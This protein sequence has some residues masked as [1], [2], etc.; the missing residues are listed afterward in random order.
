MQLPHLALTVIEDPDHGGAYH[1]LLL[2]SADDG[3]PVEHSASELS[4]PS[5]VQAFQAGV[6]RW[7]ELTTREDEDADPVGDNVEP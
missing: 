3:R 1:W 4:F 6:T 7:T 5:A 2:H